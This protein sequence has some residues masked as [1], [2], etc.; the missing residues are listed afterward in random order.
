MA[1][2]DIA[3]FP[4]AAGGLARWG[5]VL[6]PAVGAVLMSVSK[7]IVAVSAQLLGRAQL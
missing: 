5:V 2:Y 4:L 3:A 6:A 7:V 1:G